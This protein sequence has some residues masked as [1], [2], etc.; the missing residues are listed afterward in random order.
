[1]Q[2]WIWDQNWGDL[3]EIQER[4]VAP[5]LQANTDVIISASTASGKTEAAFLPA[6][7]RVASDKSKGVQILYISPLKALIND[8]NRRLESLCERADVKLTPWHGDVNQSVK[9]KLSKSPEGVL[10]ITPE[11]L[12]AF[13]LQKGNWCQSAFKELSYIIIDEFHAFI[14]SERGI[15]LLSLLN[16]IEFLIR[17]KIP[18]IALSATLGELQTVPKF[19][20]PNQ[21]FPCEIIPDSSGNRSELKLQLRGYKEQAEMQS[22]ESTM[23]V[24]KDDLFRLLRGKSNLLFANS[25]ARTE[26]LSVGLSDRCFNLGVPNEFF[27]HHGNL[28][29]EDRES[30]EV[31]LQAE[32]LPTTAVCTMTLELGIDIGNVDSVVLVTPPHS[33]SSLRQR[34]GRAGRRGQPAVIRLFI[35]EREI[36]QDM[37]LQDKLRW[38]TFQSIAMVNLLLEK[39]YEPPSDSNFHLSTLVQQ[40]L[41]VTGQYGGVQAQ[42]LYR[43][44]C[45]EGPFRKIDSPIF[46]A[47]LKSLGYHDQLIQTTDGQIVLGSKGERTVEHYTFYAAFTSSVEYRLEADGK[48]IGTLPVDFPLIEDQIIIFSGRRWKVKQVDHEKRLILLSPAK[49]GKPPLFIG[50]FGAVHDRVRQEMKTIYENAIAPPYLNP[51]AK[52]LFEEGLQSH[53]NFNLNESSLVESGPDLNVITWAGDIVTYTL[54]VLF[55]SL[56][57]AARSSNGFLEISICSKDEFRDAVKYLLNN[58]PVPEDLLDFLGENSTEKHDRF[59]PADILQLAKANQFLDLKGA[60]KWLSKIDIL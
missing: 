20:R 60:Y 2:R 14:G 3:R 22:E 59:I 19:L 24:L 44:L 32:K 52:E 18:R 5:I 6:I 48:P 50:G 35:P 51:T 15:Q 12:E 10:L 39:W 29:K 16:R 53:T 58:R 43:L 33:V 21:D 45:K 17:R 54:E 42:Q 9:Q 49:G 37:S 41:S 23:T 7:S 55:S 38:S 30:L 40:I 34:I 28:S 13:L 56:G 57:M 4:A 8:Q 31:R 11:S 46:S 36:T 26:E 1:M 47:V 25:R 27:P